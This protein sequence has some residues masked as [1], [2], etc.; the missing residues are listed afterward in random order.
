MALV[1]SMWPVVGPLLKPA[2]DHSNGCYEVEDVLTDIRNGVQELWVDWEEGQRINAAMTTL[3][4]Q[5]PR[6]KTL[7]IVFVGGSK[8]RKWL[9]EFRSLVEA[10]AR[11]NG[12]ALLEGFFREGWV[13][14]WP[15]ARVSGVG[16]VKE[17]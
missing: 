1:D 6:K 10:Y 14:V 5:Y 11:K 8:M 9:P 4:D 17:L 7:K 15:G 13:R 2:V 3:F 16:L 12:A